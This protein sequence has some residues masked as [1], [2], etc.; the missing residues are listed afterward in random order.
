MID[1][2]KETI[3]M[4]AALRKH[5]VVRYEKLER[6]NPAAVLKEADFALELATIIKSLDDIMKPHVTFADTPYPK[7]STRS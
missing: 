3:E 1:N 2:I 5:I 7:K 4:L 6:Q